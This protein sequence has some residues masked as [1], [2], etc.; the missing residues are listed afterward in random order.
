MSEVPFEFNACVL[1]LVELFAVLS[2]ANLEQTELIK[3]S[4][5]NRVTRQSFSFLN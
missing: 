5:F 2:S 1:F 3:M 4:A